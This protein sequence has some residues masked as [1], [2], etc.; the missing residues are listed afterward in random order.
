MGDLLLP[1]GPPLGSTPGGGVHLAL[2]PL[3]LAFLVLLLICTAATAAS[4]TLRRSFAVL[5]VG[6]ALALL[7]ADGFTLAFGVG[8]AVLGVWL[9]LLPHRAT[10]FRAAVAGAFALVCLGGALGLLAPPA[11]NEVLFPGGLD[12]SFA[13]LRATPHDSWHAGLATVLAMAAAGAL[14]GLAPFHPWL[15]PAH[16]AA[17]GRVAPL[18]SG[19]FSKLGIYL[20]LR[21][22]FD[23]A[24]P[25]QPVWA[26]ALL[27]VVGI[28]SALLGGLRAT[29]E[30]DFRAALGAGT[31]QQH[32]LIAMAA[33][34]ALA[35][36]A[37]DLPPL[38]ALALAAALLL[39]LTHGVGQTLLLLAANAALQ[40]AGTRQLDRLGGLI[41]R[42]PVT[43]AAT[44]AGMLGFAAVPPGGGFAGVWLLFQALLGA[45][46]IGGLVV[47]LLCALAVGVLALSSALGAAAAIRLFA[48]A[49][50]G[51]PR[52][53]R[54]AAA[55]EVGRIPRAVLL[56]LAALSLLFGLLPSLL[57]TLLDPAQFALSGISLGARAG[58]LAVAPDTASPGYAAPALVAL[59]AVVGLAAW[60]V[61]GWRGARGQSE[62]PA[63]Q[64]GF[65]ASPPWLPFGDPTTQYGAASLTQP[66]RASLGSWLLG[67]REQLR[68]T[69]GF[70]VVQ[71]DP[72]E[73]W[74]VARL[75]VLV[76]RL[77]R[78]AA[79]VDPAR[80]PRPAAAVLAALAVL[81]TL[82]VALSR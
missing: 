75:A 63:W 27:L 50:L 73:T 8:L 11:P 10:A 51:R 49:F 71:R 47:P 22:L 45:A 67:A 77:A 20:L 62:A 55:D 44:L 26:G 78:R 9:E 70:R 36:R 21:L 19:G 3:S 58:L 7:A 76:S 81:L 23:L 52:T 82:V 25:V 66:L 31:V 42:M 38:A 37:V 57:V 65:A 33:G 24:G 46:R 1:I 64:G 12:L 61:L 56:G 4:G 48:A 32:G 43:A 79:A 35:A 40:G 18:L 80:A 28:A 6:V 39:T 69:T 29:L 68:P 16:A 34:V 59:L 13:A 5:P 74:L 54:T 41:H 14:A 17:P 53:P 60:A 72:A 30:G 15:P 2:D